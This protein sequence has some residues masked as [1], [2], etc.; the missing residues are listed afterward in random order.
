MASSTTS[1][2]LDWILEKASLG[3]VCQELE[4]AVWGSSLG[5]Y[6]SS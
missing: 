5:H 6:L 4:Q 2:G 1:G 3:K